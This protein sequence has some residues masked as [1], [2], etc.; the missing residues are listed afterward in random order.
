MWGRWPS[1]TVVIRLAVPETSEPVRGTQAKPWGD[2]CV[3][4][5]P[6]ASCPDTQMV[7]SLKLGHQCP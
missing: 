2:V 4:A 7:F 3:T 5:K 6:E 1:P